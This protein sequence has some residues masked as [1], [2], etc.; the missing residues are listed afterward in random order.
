MRTVKNRKR[1]F[2]LGMKIAAMFSCIAIA[3]VGFAAW[4]IV[5][6]TNV[7][8]TSGS[9]TAEAVDEKG[10][11]FSSIETPADTIILGKSNASVWY[12]TVDA[13]AAT[14][15]T[16]KNWLVNSSI[17]S[18]QLKGTITVSF[19]AKNVTEGTISV[20]L[21]PKYGETDASSRL[22]EL[23]TA[24]YLTV[25][26]EVYSKNPQNDTIDDLIGTAALS[27]S[28]TPEITFDLTTERINRGVFYID[29]K[30]AWGD[31]FYRN[32]PYVFFN[33][34]TKTDDLKNLAKTSLQKINDVVNNITRDGEGEITSDGDDMH[35]HVEVTGTI[36][37]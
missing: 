24:K 28:G 17:A 9:I 23:V 31:T 8:G 6:D 20:N 32:N 18:E 22:Q 13:Q 34:Q 2:A 5:N 19:E 7:V 36:P 16:S 33:A 4:I 14:S 15:F 12:P 25:T 37:A 27:T 30:F 21:I 10:L 35:Y 11:T 26:L 29:V 3:S 1:K